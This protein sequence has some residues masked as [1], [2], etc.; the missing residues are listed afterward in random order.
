VAYGRSLGR[1]PIL[2]S[3]RVSFSGKSFKKKSKKE[4]NS[5]DFSRNRIPHL[6]SASARRGVTGCARLSHQQRQQGRKTDNNNKNKKEAQKGTEPKTKKKKKQ[7]K[8]NSN[9][10]EIYLRG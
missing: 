9:H 8:K 4:K 5:P 6:G 2:F 3:F 10:I 7:N 1:L